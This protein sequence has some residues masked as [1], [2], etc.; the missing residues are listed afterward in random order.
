VLTDPERSTLAVIGKRLGRRELE[1]VASA[2][3]PDTILAWFRE[4]V[5]QKFDDFRH[6]LYPGRPPIGPDITELIVRMARENSGWGYD[7]IAGALDSLGHGVFIKPSGNILCRFGIVPAP[8]RRQQMSWADFIRSHMTVLTGIDFFT[9]EVLTW[10][11][12]ATYYVLF[13]LHLDTLRVTLAGITPHPKEEWMVQMARRAVDA[14]DGALLP[15]RFVL[16]D[17][18]TKFCASFQNTLRPAGIQPIRLPAHSPNL[19]AFAECWVRSI[20]SECLS[21]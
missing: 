13:L 15:I 2:A 10:H 4:L 14:I 12:L 11:G 19:N 5:A 20:K 6:R 17:R 1:P 8:K 16:H 18:D 7:R 9:A 21:N 3:R